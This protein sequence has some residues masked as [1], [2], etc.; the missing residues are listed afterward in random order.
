VPREVKHPPVFNRKMTEEERQKRLGILRK[1]HDEIKEHPYWEKFDR[2]LLKDVCKKFL[3]LARNIWNTSDETDP[4]YVILMKTSHDFCCM[5]NN[6]MVCEEEYLKG[7]G[8]ENMVMQVFLTNVHSMILGSKRLGVPTG[9]TYSKGGGVKKFQAFLEEDGK[10]HAYN[11]VTKEKIPVI[12]RYL[13]KYASLKNGG[14]MTKWAK[15]CI[16]ELDEGKTEIGKVWKI[17]E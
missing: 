3:L 1:T 15:E 10:Y 13:E 16:A 17:T 8:D 5:C 7:S 4:Y 14:S 2:S 6:L 12:R 11:M 9:Y